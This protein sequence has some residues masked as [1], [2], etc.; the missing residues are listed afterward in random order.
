MSS[1]IKR[2]AFGRQCV[3]TE[4]YVGD[5]SRDDWTGIQESDEKWGIPTSMRK[6]KGAAGD[7]LQLPEDLRI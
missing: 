6:L 2:C 7:T 3:I 5:R 4:F 1:G